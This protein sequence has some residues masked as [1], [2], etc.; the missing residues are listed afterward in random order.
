MLPLRPLLCRISSSIAF[1]NLCPQGCCGSE[2]RVPSSEFRSLRSLVVCLSA[3]VFQRRQGHQRHQ[4]RAVN[5]SWTV[6]AAHPFAS[7]R[8]KIHWQSFLTC[9]MRWLFV[10]RMPCV[11]KRATHLI[12]FIVLKPSWHRT[13][14][15]EARSVCLGRNNPRLPWRLRGKTTLAVLRRSRSSF[16]QKGVVCSLFHA[17]NTKMKIFLSTAFERTFTPIFT[18][19]AHPRQFQITS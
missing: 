11:T 2:F 13:R 3:Q 9:K 7:L 18:P 1:A 19:F 5:L 10:G 16:T 8:L 15:A 17:K 4:G 6:Q 12:V 14:F